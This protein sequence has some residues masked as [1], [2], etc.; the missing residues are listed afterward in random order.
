MTDILFAAYDE[1]TK[2]VREYTRQVIAKLVNEHGANEDWISVGSLYYSVS[3]M[4]LGYIMDG[5]PL[6]TVDEF[7]Q[8]QLAIVVDVV[9]GFQEP[10]G[11][12]AERNRQGRE[13]VEYEEWRQS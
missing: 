7:V 9:L 2:E 5:K 10:W 4:H 8:R 1:H 12:R 6:L 3:G 11:E 13:E